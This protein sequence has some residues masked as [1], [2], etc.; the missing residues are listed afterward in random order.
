MSAQRRTASKRETSA[1]ATPPRRAA[2]NGT[3][4]APQPAP[5]PAPSPRPAAPA[6]RPPKPAERT[7]ATPEPGARGALATRSEGLRRLYADTLSEMKKI[8]WPDRE[9]TKNLTLVVIGISIALGILLGGIDF[10]LQ[11]LFEAVP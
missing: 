11:A 2:T 5:A 1:T 6:G 10:L 7:R 9:T 8:N 3:R 4:P